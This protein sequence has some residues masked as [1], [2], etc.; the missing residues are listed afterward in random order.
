MVRDRNN[1]SIEK[2]LIESVVKTI[3]WVSGY[4]SQDNPSQKFVVN[5]MLKPLIESVWDIYKLISVEKSFQSQSLK[6]L[7]ESGVNRLLESGITNR[8]RVYGE[9]YKYI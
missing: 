2:L 5:S 7:I 6:L 1:V 8:K 9:N 3:N 4:N